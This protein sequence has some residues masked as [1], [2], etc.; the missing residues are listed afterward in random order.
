MALVKPPLPPP[1]KFI[2]KQNGCFQHQLAKLVQAREQRGYE[3][4]INKLTEKL[5]NRKVL[6]GHLGDVIEQM[7][8]HSKLM[9]DLIKNDD[10]FRIVQQRDLGPGTVEYL[11]FL[12]HDKLFYCRLCYTHADWLWCEFHKTHA[13]RGPRDISLDTYVEYLNSDMAVVALVE[14]YYHLLASCNE[15][16]EAKRVLKTLTNFESLADLLAAHNY[17]DVNADTSVYEL[18][19]FE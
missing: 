11:N 16:Q 12:Q 8:R 5:K 9:P 1:M 10:E 19:D 17:S 14:E 15:K 3:H 4:D 6:R 13:Y 7:G 2:T 18:M